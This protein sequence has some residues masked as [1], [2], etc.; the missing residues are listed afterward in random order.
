MKLVRDMIPSIIHD[1]GKGCKWRKVHGTDEHTALLKLKM[2]E[3]LDEFMEE[4]SY[5]EACDMY[6]VFCEMLKQHN[7][8]FDLVVD[9]ASK[10]RLTRGGFSSGIVLESVDE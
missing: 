7:L 4:P 3:E 10:K 9:T 6:E 8:H 5:E 1:S 2:I